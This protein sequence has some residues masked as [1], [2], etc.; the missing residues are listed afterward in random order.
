[1]AVSKRLLWES[2]ALSPDEVERRETALHHHLMGKP[3]AMEG[4]TAYLEKR[5]PRWSSRVS[6]DWPKT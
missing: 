6:R 4:P 3:D 5:P 1:V 2:M